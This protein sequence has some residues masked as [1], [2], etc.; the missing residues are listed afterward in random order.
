MITT[1]FH[2]ETK[3]LSDNYLNNL[4]RHYMTFYWK[5]RKDF[6]DYVEDSIS[7]ESLIGST[8]SARSTKS[9]S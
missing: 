9:V 2:E 6:L 3:F 1:T 5:I 8:I 4:K 7:H